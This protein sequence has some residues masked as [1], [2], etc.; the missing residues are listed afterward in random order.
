M[1]EAHES[2]FINQFSQLME[3]GLYPLVLFRSHHLGDDRYVA[4]AKKLND[5]CQQH[6]SELIIHRPSLKSLQADTFKPYQWR[7][8]NSYILQSLQTR[9]FDQ[10]I[11]LS[12]SCHDEAELKMAERL[13]CMFA[14]LSTVRE[15]QS[16][17]G[18]DAKGWLGFK[19]MIDHTRLPIYALGGVKRKDY[20]IARFQGAVG[21]AGITDFW[22]VR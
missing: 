9:P 1:P 15:T 18:R 11:K 4:V 7:H 6:K 5:I 22:S 14:F 3:R 2:S 8:L 21:V 19:N 16:H 10:S 12:A 20:C 13:D 17:P